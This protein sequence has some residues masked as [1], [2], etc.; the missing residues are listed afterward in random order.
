MLVRGVQSLLVKDNALIKSVQV[1]HGENEM[2]ISL[3]LLSTGTTGTTA[4]VGMEAG[5]P[6]SPQTKKE[7]TRHLVHCFYGFCLTE[8]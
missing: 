4:S 3:K 2:K 6:C 7:Q 1:R 8:A 5:L